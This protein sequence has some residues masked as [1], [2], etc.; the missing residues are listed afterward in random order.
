M[1]IKKNPYNIL[2][3]LPDQEHSKDVSKFSFF[4][5]SAETKKMPL[6]NKKKIKKSKT[7]NTI[8]YFYSWWML[9]LNHFQLD[10]LVCTQ[11]SV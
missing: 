8:H 11:I 5:P 3:L 2:Q 1:G 6:K 7:Q 9:L 10:M 4:T